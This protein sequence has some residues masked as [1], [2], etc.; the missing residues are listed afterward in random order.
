MLLFAPFA[1]AT[2]GDAADGLLNGLSIEDLQR[3]TLVYLGISVLAF[4]LVWLIGYLRR[5]G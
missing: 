4:V 5:A 3:W 1:Y 2:A